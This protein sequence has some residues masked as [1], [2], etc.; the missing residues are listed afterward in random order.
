MG[1]RARDPQPELTDE[2]STVLFGLAERAAHAL[3]DVRI[4]AEMFGRLE[5]M[6][7]NMEAIGRLRWM[8]R[9]R[10]EP[11]ETAENIAGLPDDFNRKVKDALS[12]YWGGPRLTRSDLLKLALV[13]AALP[14]HEDNPTRA[15]R[16]VLQEAVE[17]LR[18]EGARSMTAAEWMLYNILEMRFIQGRKV[19]DVA[20]RL[21]MSESDFYRKQR[22]AVAELA[23]TLTDMELA[24]QQEG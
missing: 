4:Q 18:P 19:R 3:R 15:L 20:M 6:T 22:A 1:I 12:H 21:A 23:R 8:T 5:E 11:G 9:Y 14:D 13:Q 2:E 17:R 7:P 24:A 16:T 10:G